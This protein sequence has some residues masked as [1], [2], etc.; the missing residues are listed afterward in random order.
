MAGWL[1]AVYYSFLPSYV[2]TRTRFDLPLPLG[3]VEN[4]L[5]IKF[6]L[7]HPLLTLVLVCLLE[8][9]QRAITMRIY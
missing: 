4:C 3:A 7:A 8:A 5:E 1:K 6:S 9:S 2:D